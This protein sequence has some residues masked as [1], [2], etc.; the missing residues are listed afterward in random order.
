MDGRKDA[1]EQIATDRNLDQLKC[2]G[3]GMANSSRPSLQSLPADQCLA[4]K[5][6]DCRPARDTEVEPHFFHPL[7]GQPGPI[8]YLLAFLDVLRGSAKLIIEPNDPIRLQ[9]HVGED[10][11]DTGKQFIEMP[12]DPGDDPE[13]FVPGRRLILKVAVDTFHA[14]GGGNPPDA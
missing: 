7:A 5:R 4:R 11:T 10:E 13:R 2:D 14:F 9:L 6:Q 3:T 1:V 8:D 12:L